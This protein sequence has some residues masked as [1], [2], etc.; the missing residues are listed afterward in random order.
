M[1]PCSS[2]VKV[3]ASHKKND[4]KNIMLMLF[5]LGSFR[6]LGFVEESD[7]VILL[8]LVAEILLPFDSKLVVRECV[9]R[10]VDRVA[11]LNDTHF[12]GDCARKLVGR[13]WQKDG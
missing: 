8:G 10:N 5:S 2:P 12:G 4:G 13:V 9:R 3:L 6:T 1:T 11:F 7:R